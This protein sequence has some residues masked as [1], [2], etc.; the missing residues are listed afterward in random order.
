MLWAVRPAKYR[1]T[2]SINSGFDLVE[3]ESSHTKGKEV[4]IGSELRDDTGWE[5][6]SLVLGEWWMTLEAHL[7]SD[8]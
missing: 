2:D 8:L 5:N 6:V 1:S 7:C 3:H 4:E